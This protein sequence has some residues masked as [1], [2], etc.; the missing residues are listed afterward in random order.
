[1]TTLAAAQLESLESSLTI[2]DNSDLTDVDLSSLSCV[3]DFTIEG[4][5]LSEDDKYDLLV[6]LSDC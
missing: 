3:T 2:R 5:N 1:M 4:N 6:L